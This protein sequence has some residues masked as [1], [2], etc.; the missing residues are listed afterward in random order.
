MTVTMTPMQKTLSKHGNSYALVIE[1]PILEILQA[2]PETVFN[3]ATDGRCLMITPARTAEEKKRIDEAA[4]V[5][6]K[7]YNGLFKRLA[8]S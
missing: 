5:I 2:T 6:R 7:R 8:K 4:A 1:K 3:I